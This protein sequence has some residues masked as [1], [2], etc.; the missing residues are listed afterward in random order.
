MNRSKLVLLN[1]VY[2]GR[3][4]TET[5]IVIYHFNAGI[6]SLCETLPDEIFTGDFVS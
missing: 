3:N 1:G 4:L 6:N 2:R 5:I